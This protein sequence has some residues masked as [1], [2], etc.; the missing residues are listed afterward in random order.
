MEDNTQLILN[1]IRE[2]AR[3]SKAMGLR[4]RLI[5]GA[6]GWKN[7]VAAMKELGHEVKGDKH[8]LD[9]VL[10]VKNRSTK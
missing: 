6:K 9:G 7:L 2:A 4:P 3:A 5:W 8:E 1:K 10:L